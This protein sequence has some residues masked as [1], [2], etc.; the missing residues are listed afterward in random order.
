MRAFIALV[1]FLSLF[2]V[3]FLSAEERVS[4]SLDIDGNGQYDALTDG[5]LI[6]RYLFGLTDSS[7]TNGT[8][9]AN[10]TRTE[11]SQ[12]VSLLDSMQ[13]TLDID[14]N[15]S[16]DALTDG[17]LILRYLFGL[18]GDAL[19][20]SVIGNDSSRD[21]A[22]SIETYVKSVMPTVTLIEGN[23]GSGQFSF[24]D[25]MLIGGLS[26]NVFCYIP[27]GISETTP[28]LF[29]FHGGGRN[30]RDYRN[31][32]VSEANEKKFIV[33]APEFS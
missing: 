18:R 1:I 29:V 17:L 3:S 22:S 32:F 5:L 19:I 12:I 7:L 24:Q 21:S 10:A 30:P 8:L 11:P 6:V 15:Q 25:S 31:A 4:A 20:D 26:I 2:K 23:I 33:I 27:D 14:G 13:D 9:G 16:T 28:I